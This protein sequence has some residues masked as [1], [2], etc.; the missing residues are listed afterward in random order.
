MIIVTG[1]AVGTEQTIDEM[2]VVSLE[3][4][5]RSRTEPGCVRHAVHRDVENPLRLVFFEE[6]EDVDALRRHF[7]LPASTTFVE[8]LAALAVEPPTLRVYEA[9]KI[10][11]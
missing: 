6:W 5:R 11:I 1:S 8:R 3:H 9:N 10:R 7:T 4:V 2:L